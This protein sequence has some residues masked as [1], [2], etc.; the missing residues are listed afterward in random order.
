[1]KIIKDN[2]NLFLK[3][4][5]IPWPIL[6]LY[7][8]IVTVLKIL[9]PSYVPFL[10]VYYPSKDVYLFELI[11]VP[12]VFFTFCLYVTYLKVNR[13]FFKVGNN[14]KIFLRSVFIVAGGIF[15]FQ[16]LIYLFVE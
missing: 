11:F 10:D 15:L 6:I 3:D 7:V 9:I 5:K 8:V 14:K 2:F 16:F 4:V 13:D 1:M 12:L